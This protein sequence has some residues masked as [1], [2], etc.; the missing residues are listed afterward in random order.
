MRQIVAVLGIVVVLAGVAASSVGADA[1]RLKLRIGG[2]AELVS[3]TSVR[4]DVSYDCPAE[5]ETALLAAAV[6]QEGEGFA[7][8]EVFFDIPCTGKWQTIVVSLV[9]PH[10]D[11][12]LEF[13]P[14]AATAT[15][16]D[17]LAETEPVFAERKVRLVD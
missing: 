11:F 2:Q 12:G 15:M 9:S 8:T 6:S 3:P 13:G 10:P 16:T 17:E 14:A 4:L 5:N 7:S 1:D